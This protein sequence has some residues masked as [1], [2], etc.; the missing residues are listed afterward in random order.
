MGHPAAAVPIEGDYSA[1]I[2]WMK[3]RVNTSHKEWSCLHFPFPMGKQ[4]RVVP[5]LWP[6]TLKA[7][8]CQAH[9]IVFKAAVE[10]IQLVLCF[11]E[12]EK[13]DEK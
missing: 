7:P 13:Y 12:E 10:Q 9:W 2:A 1:L 8:H 11:K 6:G 5:I 4:G 3:G